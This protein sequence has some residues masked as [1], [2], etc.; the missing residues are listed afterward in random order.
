M[1]H[2]TKKKKKKTEVKRIYSPPLSELTA[3]TSFIYCDLVSSELRNKCKKEKSL[4]Q[5]IKV[6]LPLFPSRERLAL[7]PV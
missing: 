5:Q 1:S 7:K 4:Q 2:I 6:R 3:I